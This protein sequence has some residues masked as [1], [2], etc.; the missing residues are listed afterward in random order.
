VPT[1]L[2]TP[3]SP[4]EPGN[5]G[6][7]NEPD[8]VSHD[9]SPQPAGIPPVGRVQSKPPTPQPTAVDW[10]RLSASDL[11]RQWLDLDRWVLWL[12]RT[13][14]LPAS[15]IP[16]LWHRH[17]EL[18][19]ELSA[20]HL[21]W[22]GAYQIAQTPSSPLGWHRDFAEAITRLRNWTSTTG[23]RLDRDRPTRQTFWPGEDQSVEDTAER[24]IVDRE[25]DFAA[26][27]SEQVSRRAEEEH[28]P[29]RERIRC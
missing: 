23:S 17:P 4:I 16:P 12:R 9:Q 20:L 15:V 22:L 11:K 29:D 14:G 27:V 5:D 6:R 7:D 21:H 25:L 10:N 1:P 13:Y 26:H 3:A 2:A 19:W 8:Q 18:V 28:S 24:P